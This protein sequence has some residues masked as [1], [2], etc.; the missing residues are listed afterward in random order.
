MATN[1]DF[2]D[3]EDGIVY[4]AQYIASPNNQTIAESTPFR[5]YPVL[6]EATMNLPEV[7]SDD[8]LIVLGS[9]SDSEPELIDEEPVKDE[10]EE[11]AEKSDREG[12]TQSGPWLEFPLLSISS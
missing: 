5:I 8:G 6:E 10:P 1:D 12:E 9:G 3:S 2:S 11:K 7:F 4:V